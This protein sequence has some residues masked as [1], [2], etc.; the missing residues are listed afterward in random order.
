VTVAELA[1]AHRGSGAWVGARAES[2]LIATARAISDGAKHAWIY[3]VDVRADMRGKGVGKLLMRLLLDHP[4]VR[5]AR[6]V[7]LQTRDA[8]E[9]YEPF[10][11]VRRER[12]PRPYA[13]TAMSLFRPPM[14]T[15]R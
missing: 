15:A 10:G 5:R 11:F 6:K 12:I 2:G 1:E 3:D 8:M 7:H 9:F 4:R 14:E 13:S